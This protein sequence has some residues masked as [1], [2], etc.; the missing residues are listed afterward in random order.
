VLTRNDAKW[1]AA[2]RGCPQRE[3][4]SRR[5][6]LSEDRLRTTVAWRGAWSLALQSVVKVGSGWDTCARALRT[7]SQRR[8]HPARSS[9]APP[10]LDPDTEGQHCGIQVPVPVHLR[11][12]A[13]LNARVRG[14]GEA[15]NVRTDVSPLPC[16]ASWRIA[17][18]HPLKRLN[19][20]CKRLERPR[21]C[22][23]SVD[24]VGAVLLCLHALFFQG[25]GEV[26]H[27]ADEPTAQQGRL[28][29]KSNTWFAVTRHGSVCA[30]APPPRHISSP[31]GRTQWVL[32]GSAR[33][34]SFSKNP[35]NSAF[36]Q[37]AFSTSTRFLPVPEA[38]RG[39]LAHPDAPRSSTYLDDTARCMRHTGSCV[40]RGAET[41]HPS[42]PSP[43]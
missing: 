4:A 1:Q 16:E 42:E 36:L 24:R 39:S 33:G 32:G 13:L 34:R 26:S 27:C 11:S 41:T 28:L 23:V 14:E 17:C 12:L 22:L 18:T 37:G 6:R 40:S 30:R 7:P 35:I 21:W 15:A 43:S 5:H 3:H 19:S 2:A 25:Q 10:R 38:T 20:D 8:P 31:S 9:L 29:L